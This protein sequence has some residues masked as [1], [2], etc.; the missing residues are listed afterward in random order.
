[1]GMGMPPPPGGPKGGAPG[2]LPGVAD[3]GE[4]DFT[5]M[6]QQMLSQAQQIAGQPGQQATVKLVALLKK[7]V[8]LLE[9]GGEGGGEEGPEGEMMGGGGGGGMMGG[10]RG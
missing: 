10:M 7:I 5:A 4:A 2:G 3:A 9:G 1:M 8:Q 6:V